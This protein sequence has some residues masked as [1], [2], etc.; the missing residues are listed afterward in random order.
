MFWNLAAKGIKKTTTLK[1]LNTQKLLLAATV[2]LVTVLNQ[3][4]N[5]LN[6]GSGSMQISTLCNS[7][8]TTEEMIFSLWNL[9]HVFV[10][11]LPG[12]LLATLWPD[13][14]HKT[15]NIFLCPVSNC[16]SF[17]FVIYYKI[18]LALFQVK[19]E[20]VAFCNSTLPWV[21]HQY[22]RC[23]PQS[24]NGNGNSKINIQIIANW[25]DLCCFVEK[26]LSDFDLT[27]LHCEHC[28]FLAALHVQNCSSAKQAIE[29]S[30]TCF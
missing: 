29:S 1:T 10:N 9:Q 22:A 8:G 2:S 5:D 19:D 26:R 30:A 20:L 11:M 6:P 12:L 18:K 27:L 14:Q 21:S 13:H 7:W 24:D 17:P 3:W 4:L 28:H 23:L 16:V 25:A 15:A